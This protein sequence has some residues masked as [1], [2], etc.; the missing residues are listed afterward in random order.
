[1]PAVDKL[2][3]FGSFARGDWVEDTATHYYS[4]FDLAALVGEEKEV[5]DLAL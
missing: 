2:I 3:L 1:M 4:D 5:A